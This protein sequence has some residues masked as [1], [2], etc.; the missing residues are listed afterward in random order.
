[1]LTH[2]AYFRLPDKKKKLTVA[3]KQKTG[4][5]LNLKCNLRGSEQK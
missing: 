4:K 5:Y 2:E 3:W 1:M